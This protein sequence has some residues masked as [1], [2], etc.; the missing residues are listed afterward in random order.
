MWVA[1]WSWIIPKGPLM[2]NL[3]SY[4]VHDMPCHAR[5]GGGRNM[6]WELIFPIGIPNVQSHSLY[7]LNIREA[8]LQH[9]MLSHLRSSRIPENNS[10]FW[11][12]GLWTH[13]GGCFMRARRWKTTRSEC[14]TGRQGSDSL[15]GLFQAT[16]WVLQTKPHMADQSTSPSLCF[17]EVSHN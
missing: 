11:C 9:K 12:V 16:C 8:Q 5:W 1:E 17:V 13:M 4:S 3:N 7:W 10:V 2:H 14:V 15:S 6:L